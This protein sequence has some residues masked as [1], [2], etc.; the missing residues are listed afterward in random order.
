MLPQERRRRV[1]ALVCLV[2]LTS[3]SSVRSNQ[4]G[5][6]EPPRAIQVWIIGVPEFSIATY[7]SDTLKR[8]IEERC[9]EVETFFEKRLRGNVKVHSYCTKERTTKAAIQALFDYDIANLSAG[10]LTLVFMISHGEVAQFA[11]PLQKTDVE[12]IASDTTATNPGDDKDPQRLKSSV[13]VGAYLLQQLS[14]WPAEST[15]LLFLDTCHSG[16]A[17][18][19]N[20]K[21]ASA[22]RQQFAVRGLVMASSM[23]GE[24][25]Y[26]ALFTSAILSKFQSQ[27]CLNQDTLPD[28]VQ[29]LISK[30]VNL[31][32]DEGI[33]VIVEPYD[34]PL[35]LG[36]FGKDRRLLFLYG[37]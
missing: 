22:L 25:S 10:T 27:E 23:P 28:E 1:A 21:V 5:A 37:G 11:N 14:H 26:R 29:A 18:S 34:G 24:L 15:V 31:D 32:L 7:N 2:W 4:T 33:P 8:S 9:G 6:A 30:E 35:C 16:A 17:A 20:S 12:F 3:L 36:N 13:L 19:I